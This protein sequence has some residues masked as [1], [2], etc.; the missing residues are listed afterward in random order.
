MKGFRDRA[1]QILFPLTLAWV[2]FC[3]LAQESES[4]FGLI[5]VSEEHWMHD[6]SEVMVAPVIFAAF[7]AGAVYCY[8]RWPWFLQVPESI[9]PVWLTARL[10]GYAPLLFAL[11][12]AAIFSAWW[13][14]VVSGEDPAHSQYGLS[15]WFAAWFYSTYLT[16]L[17]TV[18]IVWL[19]A[20]RRDRR[21][22]G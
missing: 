6:T 18:V 14:F 1:L 17:F 21:T 20:L 3:V 5:P 19:S 16:P 10:L 11:L 15:A 8:R 13:L 4:V 7:V 9:S 2:A 22:T 12:A